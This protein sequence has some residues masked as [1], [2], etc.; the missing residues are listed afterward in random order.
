MNHKELE[1]RALE[2]YPVML[3]GDNYELMPPD[4]DMNED[5]RLAYIKGYS[6]RDTEDRWVS[7]KTPPTANDD[8]LCLVEVD[9]SHNKTISKQIVCAFTVGIWIVHDYER[10]IMWQPLPAPPKPTP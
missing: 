7:A 10:V 8:Y 2:I 3:N 6:D 4:Y 9:C 5:Y 1:N